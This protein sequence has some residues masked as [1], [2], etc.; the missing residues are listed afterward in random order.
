[1]FHPVLPQ[2]QALSDGIPHPLSTSHFASFFF[3]SAV[4]LRHKYPNTP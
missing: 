3:L 1:M 4:F 2:L